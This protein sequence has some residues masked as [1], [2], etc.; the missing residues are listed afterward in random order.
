MQEIVEQLRSVLRGLWFYKWWGFITTVIFGI[1]GVIAAFVIPSKYEAAA[2]VYVDTQSILKPLMQGLAVQP[3]VEQQVAM[4][5]RTLISRPNIDRV[6]RMADLDLKMKSAGERELYIDNLLK[7]VEFKAVQGA[8]NLYLIN[9]RNE[10]PESA[11]AVVQALLGIFVEGSLVKKNTDGDTARRFLDEQIKTS[12]QRLLQAEEAL[13]EFK[14]KNLNVMPNLAQDYIAKSG[15]F[16]NQ[17]TQAKLELRQAEYARDAIKTQL[18]GEAATMALPGGDL[19]PIEAAPK[20][21]PTELDERVES[22]RKRLDDFR[23][24][25]TEE[26]PDVVGTRRILEQL[27]S[28]RDVERRVEAARPVP[29]QQRRQAQQ[30]ANPVFQQLKI[31]L[32]D[33][34]AQIASLRARVADYEI[35]LSKSREAALT[36]PKVEAQYI[37]LTRDYDVNRKHYEQLLERR[38]S[39]QTST[40]MDG[41]AGVAEFRVV[42]PPRVSAQPV[43]P[44]RNLLLLLG[45][46]ASIGAGF[47]AAFIRDQSRPTFF[48][49]RTLRN[50]TQVPILG[51]VSLFNDAKAKSRARVSGMTFAGMSALYISAFLGLIMYQTVLTAVK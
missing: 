4:M 44:N 23:S 45:L 2:R 51:A 40:E 14:I 13:K 12:E 34:E 25:F 5:G 8:T 50:V 46:L 37:Q 47:A 15:D 16:Q 21:R 26:H 3:N 10:K 32:A 39:A 20:A 1:G 11:K 48:D 36:I 29:A 49:L 19:G 31:S 24:R 38:Q 30:A 27:E 17:V 6:M 41:A 42:D 35:R 43:W 18:N 7:D 33:A 22:T 9:Y 28:Q